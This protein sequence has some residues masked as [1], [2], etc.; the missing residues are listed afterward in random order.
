MPTKSDSVT[1]G[2]PYRF[3]VV[4]LKHLVTDAYQRPL[5]TF[6]DKIEKNFDPALVGTVCLSERTKTKYAVIDGQTRAEGMKR[7]GMAKVPAI[8]YTG[9]TREQEAALF[10]KFQ[11]ERRGMTSSSLF[12]AKVISGDKTA[13][14]INEIVE[15]AGFRVDPNVKS[16]P[17][18]V[19]NAI[20]AT[21]ALEFVYKGTFGRRGGAGKPD[22]EL[23]RDTLDVV[24]AA[25]PKLPETAKGATMLRG[26]AWFLARN[27]N[28]GKERTEMIDTDKLVT[29][30]SKVT[31]SDLASRGEKL[32]EARGMSGNS[33]AYLAEAI[34]SVYRKR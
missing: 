27:L 28:T 16:S 7:L 2:L 1:N 23:L 10:A 24:K 12:K 34:D 13:I 25:W 29:K 30:L 15:D 33:P 21:A 11:T 3:E 31:P 26:L 8:V 5:T 18:N 9:L 20:A 19:N 6:V 22:P 32:R 14:A 4:D 17:G